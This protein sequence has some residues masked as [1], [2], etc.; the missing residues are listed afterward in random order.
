MKKRQ[1]IDALSIRVTGPQRQAIEKMSIER[2]MSLGEAARE[3]LQE[4]IELRGLA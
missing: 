3:L 2:D 4:A 1:L